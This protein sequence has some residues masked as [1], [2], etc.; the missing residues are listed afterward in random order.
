MEK[1]QK[2]T[3][4]ESIEK[5]K[6]LKTKLEKNDIE[7]KT[8]LLEQIKEEVTSIKENMPHRLQNIYKD[9]KI[10]EKELEYCLN[11]CQ[12]KSE[13]KKDIES[14]KRKQKKEKEKEDLKTI[15][16]N[17][18]KYSE[19][20]IKKLEKISHLKPI[21]RPKQKLVN[22]I[23]TKIINRKQE[24]IVTQELEELLEIIEKSKTEHENKELK[25]KY[26]K[27]TNLVLTLEQIE[28]MCETKDLL[29]ITELKNKL[30]EEYKTIIKEITTELSK[31]SKEKTTEKKYDS[32]IYEYVYN[33]QNNGVTYILEQSDID[34]FHTL[35][36][37]IKQ[38]DELEKE[39]SEEKKNSIH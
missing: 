12:N 13:T 33:K 6:R 10:N 25:E 24:K 15:L 31:E 11:L 17:I 26:I 27:K 19:Q 30:I 23:Y 3:I 22:A 14:L 38:L 32:Q 9:G 5:L 39:E 4:E 18:K 1:E 2:K 20:Q 35:L 16:E 34:S 8:E 7:G 28:T 36:Q 29:R 21:K 37:I